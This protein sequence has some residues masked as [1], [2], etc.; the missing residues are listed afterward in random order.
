MISDKELLVRKMSKEAA[1]ISQ[2]IKQ[3][4]QTTFITKVELANVKEVTSC[5]EKIAKA[6]P[7]T[8][9]MISA[10]TKENRL[11]SAVHVPSGIDFPDFLT[12]TVEAT[13]IAS[14]NTFTHDRHVVEISYPPESEQYAFKTVDVLNGS[15]FSL[16]K[17]TGLYQEESSEEE[18]GT[19]F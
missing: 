10:A 9:V 1:R 16:L 2:L 3:N 4:G 5:I 14:E 8:L 12:K 18:Y 7:D 11:I 19:D 13:G 15:A 6:C 17:K